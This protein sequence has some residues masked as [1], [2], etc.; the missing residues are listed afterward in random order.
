M[1]PGI[2]ELNR[3]W[4]YSDHHSSTRD[5]RARAIPVLAE[6][7][8]FEQTDDAWY[9]PESMDRVVAMAFEEDYHAITNSPGRIASAGVGNGYSRMANTAFFMAEFIRALGYRALP[10]GNEVGLSI[11]MAVDAG[12]GEVG[13]LGVLITPKYGPRVRLAKVITDMPL[14]ID[15]PIRFGVREFC[16]VC[17]LC[18]THCPSGSQ[19]KV[20][21]PCGTSRF[22][23]ARLMPTPA[24]PRQKS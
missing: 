17:M 4:L 8:R 6:G 22:P 16:E 24:M 20:R 5:D 3:L 9:I 13:R 21:R 18:A 15:R 11:P 23:C 7:E 19:R 10:A 12:L 1:R 2:A 14:G